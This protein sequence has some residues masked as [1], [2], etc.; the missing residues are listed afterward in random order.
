MQL[1]NKKNFYLHLLL[2]FAF[3]IRLIA[4]YYYGDS[5]IEYEWAVLLDHLYE[6]NILAFYSFDGVLIP[7]VFMPPLYVYFLYLIKM[8]TPEG[9]LLTNVVLYVQVILSTIGILL[10][11]KINKLFFSINWCIFNSFILSIFP[12]NVY[13]VTQISSITLQIFSELRRLMIFCK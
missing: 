3:L 2:F 7:S 5:K 6:Q 12:L 10:F 1:I 11:F 8:F 13:T 4:V 9:I